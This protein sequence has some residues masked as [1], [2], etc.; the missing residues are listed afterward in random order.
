MKITLIIEDIYCAQRSDDCKK[1]C[2]DIIVDNYK[3]FLIENNSEHIKIC[4]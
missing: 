1:A 4:E 3:Y 2:V